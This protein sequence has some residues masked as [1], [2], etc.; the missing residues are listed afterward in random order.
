[1]E[2]TSPVERV[3]DD[4]ANLS[5]VLPRLCQVVFPRCYSAMY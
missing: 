5:V 4:V 3:Q 2:D 1:L